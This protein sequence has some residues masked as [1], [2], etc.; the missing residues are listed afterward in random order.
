MVQSPILGG[1]GVGRSL[2]AEDSQSINLFLEVVDGKDGA[3]PAFLQMAPGLDLMVTLGP[4]PIRG[5][6]IMQLDGVAYVVSGNQ[7][8]ALFP[9]MT[10]VLLGTLATSDGYISAITNGTQIAFFDGFAGYL[11]TTKVVNAGGGQALTG[12]TIGA[13]SAGFAVG[14]TINLGAVG[15]EQDATAILTVTGASLDG[16]VATYTIDDPGT[17]YN[18]NPGTPTIA[19]SGSGT[20]LTL[21]I[22]AAAGPISASS[23]AIGGKN[24][25]A[26]DTGEVTTGTGDA[27]YSVTSVTA[28]GAVTSFQV[29]Q[30]GLF[31]E[32]PTSFDEVSTSSNGAN[33]T[34]TSPTFG[35]SQY[36]FGIQL[37]F[38][39]GPAS[40]AYQDGFGLVNDSGTDQF[41]QSDLYDLSIWE[42]LNFSSADAQPDD[43]RFIADLLRQVFLFKDL[44]TEVWVN[45]GQPGFSFQRL[46]GVFI[47]FGVT[48]PFSVAK[49]GQSLLWLAQNDQGKNVVVLADSLGVPKRVSTHAL[50]FQINRYTNTADA[51]G[52]VYQMEGHEFYVLTFPTG[53]ATWV[54][55][56]TTTEKLGQPMWHQRAAYANGEFSRWWG[57]AFLDPRWKIGPQGQGD[58]K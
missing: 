36:I 1:F 16:A 13:G 50:E 6:R 39:G 7:M 34:L 23:I 51:F 14:D 15:G 20:G 58:I 21:N 5:P 2:N 33:F 52:F 28:F 44:N 37:P 49:A 29:T 43:V 30:G 53:D 24:Y 8:W 31:S 42:P 12:G 56:L 17:T 27:T 4:G 11:T 40:A 57:N 19:T 35:A 26:G 45:V 3:A 18:T 32:A 9:N 22:T 38:S 41:Y 54:F 47:E 55:D 25:A 10:A 46:Q 48:A